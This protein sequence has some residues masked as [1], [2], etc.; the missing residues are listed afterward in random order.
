MADTQDLGSCG[1]SRAGSSPVIRIPRIDTSED[2]AVCD[3]NEQK[4]V[5]TDDDGKSVEYSV[6]AVFAVPDG[7]YEY[8]A[9]LPEYSDEDVLL[10][11]YKENGENDFEL[12]DIE[13]EE[14]FLKAE[15]AFFEYMEL[16]DVDCGGDVEIDD[17]FIY[18][19]D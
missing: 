7:K 10:C 18:E 5:L 13:T 12:S 11:R 17:E 2:T 15:E 4:I 16:D 1:V 3:D 9:L 19:D 8:I 14:E 6:L